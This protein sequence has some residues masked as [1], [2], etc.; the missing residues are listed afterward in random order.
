MTR[1]LRYPRD[2]P[3]TKAQEKGIDVALAIDF[4][5][6]AVDC[7]HDVGVVV[8]FDTDLVPAMEFVLKR[9]NINCNVEVVGLN[10]TQTHMRRLRVHGYTT[11]CHWIDRSTYNTIADTNDY[12]L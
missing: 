2:W 12:N 10:S 11:W 4:V 9:Q 6:F 5:S 7:S 8:S 3:T 1:Q